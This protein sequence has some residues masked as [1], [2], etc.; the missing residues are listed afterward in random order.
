MVSRRGFLRVLGGGAVGGARRQEFLGRATL[1]IG[2]A[3]RHAELGIL[4]LR[5]RFRWVGRHALGRPSQRGAWHHQSGIDGEHRYG[6]VIKRWVGRAARGRREDVRDHPAQR[7]EPVVRTG[8]RGDARSGRS[9]D[10]RERLGDEHRLAPRWLRLLGDRPAPPRRARRI[11]EHRYDGF[12]RVR[13]GA[14]PSHRLD[15]FPV[16]VRWRQFG[17]AGRSARNRRR[18]G[19]VEFALTERGFR[20]R[21]R[22]RQGDRALVRRGERP[23]KTNEYTGRVPRPRCSIRRPQ[24][25]AELASPRGFHG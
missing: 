20:Q 9:R 24:A 4:H 11:V 17:S 5:A 18:R 19:V 25:N 21:R 7:V 14:A 16:V 1:C 15:S 6:E 10:H 12:E 2:S 23:R 8:V 3:R 13:H 22:P